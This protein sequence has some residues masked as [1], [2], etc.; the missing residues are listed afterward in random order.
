MHRSCLSRFSCGTEERG[1]RG[2]EASET[3]AEH[4]R[5][6]APRSRKTNQSPIPRPPKSPGDSP[7]GPR[8]A[9]PPYL[10]SSHAATRIAI[11]FPLFSSSPIGITRAISMSLPNATASPPP[12]PEP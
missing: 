6:A 11:S 10:H 4:C 7:T 3:R 9:A 5:V 1:G 12:S 2:E 8:A